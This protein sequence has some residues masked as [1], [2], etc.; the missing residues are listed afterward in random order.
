MTREFGI[1]DDAPVPEMSEI[2]KYDS[3]PPIYFVSI[4]GDSVEVDDAT[5]HDP[6]K[7]SLACMNQMGKPMMPVPKHSWRKLLIKLFDNLK[8]VP[9]PSS[10]KIDVQ[11]TEIL[12]DYINKTP[13][14]EL[15]DVMRGIAFTDKGGTSYFKFKNFWRFLLRTKSWPDKTYPK[16]KTL[17]LMQSLFGI[18]EIWKKIPKNTRVMSMKT[19]KLERPNVRINPKEKEPWE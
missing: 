15:K 18:E 17:R 3:D 14:K 10:S 13:G 4:G 16:Q 1:G 2:R 7:F 12:A 8:I 11:L 6:E 19:I 5:L 9:A